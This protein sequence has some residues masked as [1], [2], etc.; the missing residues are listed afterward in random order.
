MPTATTVLPRIG[1]LNC[2]TERDEETNLFIS[3][4]LNFDLMETGGTADE[5]WQNLKAAVKQYI[6]HCYTFYP[7]GFSQS[8]SVD[9][10]KH[11]AEVLKNCGVVSRVEEIEIALKPPLLEKEYP[12]WMQGVSTDGA[13]CAVIQ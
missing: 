4:C 10:W 6:E 3:H 12:V 7:E 13:N 11:F 5:S 1:V 8:A 2:L 9:E